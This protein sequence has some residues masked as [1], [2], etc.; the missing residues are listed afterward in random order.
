VAGLFEAVEDLSIVDR[1]LYRVDQVLPGFGI[2]RGEDKYL[3]HHSYSVYLD[4]LPL[5]SAAGYF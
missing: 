3:G 4:A 1:I 5:T 2:P